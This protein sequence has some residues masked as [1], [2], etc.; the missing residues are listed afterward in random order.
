MIAILWR[1][2][3]QPERIIDFELTYAANGDWA[4]LFAK[5]AGYLGTELLWEREGVYLTI[6]RWRAQ[7][8]FDS[9]LVM[10]RVDYEALNNI[11]DGWT[12]KEERLGVF[13]TIG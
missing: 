9:F 2:D 6:D 4:K 8:D 3:V 13:E 11:C 10:H 12:L 1:Y 7:E 5:A